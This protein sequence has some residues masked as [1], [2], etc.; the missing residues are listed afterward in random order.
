MVRS[1]FAQ[2][3]GGLGSWIVNGSLV[4]EFCLL[5]H[6]YA[7]LVT[8]G[9]PRSLRA[10][11]TRFFSKYKQFFQNMGILSATDE[12][13]FTRIL[14]ASFGVLDSGSA[15]CEHRREP[16]P[17]TTGHDNGPLLISRLREERFFRRGLTQINADFSFG[18]RGAVL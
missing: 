6:S 7:V 4:F 17:S 2:G 10:H 1:S 12:H 18:F 11:Y 13:R 5:L 15:R 8:R 14:A 3:F 9:S 16:V